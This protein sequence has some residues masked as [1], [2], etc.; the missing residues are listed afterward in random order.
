MQFDNDNVSIDVSIKVEQQQSV[1]HVHKEGDA[2]RLQ[3]DIITLFPEIIHNYCNSS[4]I[5]RAQKQNIV[6]INTVNP[7]E[8][9]HNKHKTV[10][11]TPYG[12]GAGMVLKCEP[13]Y[14]ALESI[15]R[16][17]NSKII[18]LTPQGKTYNQ[19]LASEFKN[20]E[21]LILICGHYE[22]Y[23]ERI[24]QGTDIIEISIGD[25]VLTGGELGALIIT[26]SVTRLIPGSLGKEESFHDDSFSS[27]LLEYPHYTRPYEFRGMKVPDILLSGNHKEID[28]WRRTQSIKRTYNK[29][30]DLFKK[31][32]QK[33]ISKEDR[34]ILKELGF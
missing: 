16:K 21:Q 30:P 15:E 3:F 12:G 13:F 26:D 25:F 10:D 5:G 22:G 33:E 4:I 6:S 28:K 20:L 19:E 2:Q 27:D 9:T 17:E 31:F 24:R 1:N 34:C 18:L 14:A 8:F 29:R 11:D 23:D 32:I 7:R